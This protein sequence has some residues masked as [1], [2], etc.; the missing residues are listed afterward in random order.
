MATLTITRE[1]VLADSGERKDYWAK[2]KGFFSAMS[3]VVGRYLINGNLENGYGSRLTSK[4]KAVMA[5][6]LMG[7]TFH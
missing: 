5:A 7:S 3:R 1:A 4:D 2:V 6:D